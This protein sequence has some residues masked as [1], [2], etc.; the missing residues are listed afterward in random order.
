MLKTKDEQALYEREAIRLSAI[1]AY[2][3]KYNR[4]FSSDGENGIM[5]LIYKDGVKTPF[6]LKTTKKASLPQ[7]TVKQDTDK[8]LLLLNICGAL[9]KEYG[10]YV[11]CYR[12]DKEKFCVQFKNG[13][14]VYELSLVKKAKVPTDGGVVIGAFSDLEDEILANKKRLSDTQSQYEY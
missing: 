10:E 1:A 6:Q 4:F 2:G 14:A 11:T 7:A 5:D 13:A 12:T 8:T 9:E 3:D